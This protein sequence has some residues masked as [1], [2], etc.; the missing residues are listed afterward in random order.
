MRTACAVSIRAALRTLIAIVLF[1]CGEWELGG[2][3]PPLEEFRAAPREA[4][5]GASHHRAIGFEAAKRALE[6]RVYRD[7]RI[8]IYCGCAFD[9]D[10]RLEVESC[11]YRPRRRD[12]PREHRIEWEHMVPVDRFGRGR[13]CWRGETC[14][15]GV[16]GRAC[17]TRTLEHGGDAEVRAMEG[18]LHN[19]APAVGALNAERSDREYGEVPGEPR[20][21]GRCDFEIDRQHRHGSIEPPANVRGDVARAW[22][23]MAIEYGVG[24]TDEERARMEA[25]HRADPVDA[26]ERER[27]ARIAEIQGNHNP[28]VVGAR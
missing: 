15:G 19:L 9:R 22:L 21:H 1:G 13:P 8:E 25:W 4:H 7:H 18:D 3:P 2:S 17:C 16:H 23:Y 12:G 5:A 11:G 6:D 14:T 10:R 24:L 26:W 27:D 20:E 28:Y